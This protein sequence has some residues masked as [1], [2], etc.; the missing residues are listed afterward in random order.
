MT[1]GKF[2]SSGLR[3]RGR[4]AVIA[5]AVSFFVI[6]VALAVSAGYRE[7]IRDGVSRLTGDI[8]LTRPDM[9]WYSPDTPVYSDPACRPVLETMPGVREIVPA[10][11]RGG[12]V[13]Q[14]GDIRGVL[15]K[16]VP[17]ADSSSL[18]A[19]V[20]EGLANALKLK[21]GDEMLTYF[22]GDRL[23]ARKFRIAGTYETLTTSAD[24]LIVMV[25][26]KDLQRVNG[27]DDGE[28]SALEIMLEDG[29]RDAGSERELARRIAACAYEL[30]GED[31]KN[32]TL[33]VPSVD[34][35]SRLFD[36]LTL[37]DFNVMIILALMILVAGFNMISGLLIMLF[38]NISTIGT[39][40]A[41]GMKDRGVAEVF[42]RVA[43]GTVVKGML[44]GNAIALAFCM[45]QRHTHLLKLDPANY[46]VSFVPVKVDPVSVLAVD[47]VA[48][49]AIMLLLLIPALFISKVDP[50]ETMRVK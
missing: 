18:R 14:E 23:Q 22:V 26:L 2:I 36:W 7:S 13:R 46:F 49:A 17:A 5:T 9:N 33:S 48:F 16:G 1:A 30:C 47:A 34:R 35:Y 25:P 42:L 32:P 3:F 45:V 41:L 11:Y 27:W 37:I 40:K 50:A 39:L 10:I 20:P 4:L 43:S 15:F 29:Y 8:Q 31:E 38:R 44:A 28:V 19:T 21:P 6:I 12:I 24:N